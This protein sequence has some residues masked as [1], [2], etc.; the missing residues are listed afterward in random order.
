MV[1]QSA[2]R[3]GLT[4]MAIGLPLALAVSWMLRRLFFG[5]SPFDPATF[6][7]SSALV[8]GAILVAGSLPALRAARVDPMI[9]LRAE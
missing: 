8:F 7:L 6:I 9:A 4:A 1:Q 5:L 3:L 2:A